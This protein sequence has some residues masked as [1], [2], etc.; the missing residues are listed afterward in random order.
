MIRNNTTRLALAAGLLV[1]A[2]AANAT[3][4]FDFNKALTGADPNGA[5]PWATL[6]IQDNG[7]D[8]GGLNKVLLSLTSKLYDDNNAYLDELW[9]NLTSV[10]GDFYTLT[11]LPD[12]FQAVPTVGNFTVSD[13]ELDYNALFVGDHDPNRLLAG[14]TVEWEVAGTGL[15]ENSFLQVADPHGAGKP[16]DVYA[17]LHVTGGPGSHIYCDNPVPEPASLAALALGALALFRRKR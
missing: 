16:D 8:A 17:V 15:S 12:A 1:G 2:A 9:L 14:V 10:P 6:V 3:V 4:I 11:P 7:T 13:E 5:A